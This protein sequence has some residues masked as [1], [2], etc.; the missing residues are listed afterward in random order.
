MDSL[1]T[2]NVVDLDTNKCVLLPSHDE[3]SNHTVVMTRTP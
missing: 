2:P 1:Y 3:E